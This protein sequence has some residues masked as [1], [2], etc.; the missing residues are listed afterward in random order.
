MASLDAL[1][2]AV[3]R[4]ICDTI[5]AQSPRSALPAYATVSWTWQRAF[6][7][8]TFHSVYLSSARLDQLG[9]VIT[10]ERQGYVL[11]MTLHVALA[12]YHRTQRD[13]LETAEDGDRATRV[14]TSTIQDFFGTLSRWRPADG[15][16]E[17]IHLE[18]LVESPSD[19][20]GGGSH[21]QSYSKRSRSPSTTRRARSAVV[22]IDIPGHALPQ[23]PLVSALTCSGRH[24]ELSSVLFLLSRLPRLRLLDTEVEHDTTEDRDMEQRRGTPPSPPPPCMT[25][26]V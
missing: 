14:L 6:E 19:D 15:P 2:P 24:M 5:A 23:T 18:L 1:P 8:H 21:Y 3:F 11:V 13:D 4:L 22:R 10:R 25:L 16:P 26:H 20:A 17:G 7:R 9:D 12:P